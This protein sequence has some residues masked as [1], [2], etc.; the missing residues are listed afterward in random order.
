MD[1]KQHSYGYIYTFRNGY[2][3]VY[4]EATNEYELYLHTKPQQLGVDRETA[5]LGPIQEAELLNYLDKTPTP[6]PEA[7]QKIVG[8][9]KKPAKAKAVAPAPAPAKDK[10]EQIAPRPQQLEAART[11]LPWE[12]EDDKWAAVGISGFV[13]TAAMFVLGFGAAR[14]RWY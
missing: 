2:K 1:R 6:K 9:G 11:T 14:K 8:K 3:L 10:D 4:K 13:F 12:K 5:T 7:W